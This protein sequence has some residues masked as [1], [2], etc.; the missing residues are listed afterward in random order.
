MYGK[1]SGLGR[2]YIIA[3]GDTLMLFSKTTHIDQTVQAKSYAN[4]AT[5]ISFFCLGFCTAAWAPLIPYAQQRLQINHADF[6]VLLLCGGL[7]SMIAMPTTGMIIQKVGCKAVIAVFLSLLLLTL[8]VLTLGNTSLMMAVALFIF[9]TAAGGLGVAINLQA[10]IVEKRNAK[11]MMSSFHG[12]CSLGG[13][14]GVMLVTTLLTLGLNPF[15]SAI[16]ITTLMMIL[17][18]VASRHSLNKQ[19]TG[20][21]SVNT[22][23]KPRGFVLPKP[24]IL[25]FGLMCFIAFLSEGSAMDWSGIYL[26]DQFNIDTAYAG[27][28]Y[29]CFAIAMTIGRFSGATIQKKMGEK[30]TVIYGAIIAALGLVTV[31]LSPAWIVALIGYL[32]IGFGCSNI[33]PIIFS[34]V[35]RQNV[36]PKATALSYV[37]TMAYSG[38]LL[39]PALIGLV[40][41]MTGLTVV[42]AVIVVFILCI[43]AL[44]HLSHKLS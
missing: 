37:S 19:D 34:Q 6:G 43:P 25:L 27:L 4:I 8:P 26:V 7:G 23:E 40:S 21:Q 28:A 33:V 30:N 11:N 13:L 5:L 35:G 12:M 3:C 41:V 22:D 16:V 44:N 24:I 1:S 38:G 10:V 17:T 42:F 31:I 14:I 29:T 39:G 20:D 18:F 32:M 36:M 2:L 9:G 15:M